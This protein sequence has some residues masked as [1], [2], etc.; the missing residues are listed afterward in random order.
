MKQRD[1]KQIE[2]FYRKVEHLNHVFLRCDTNVAKRD[3]LAAY[4][5]R[6]ENWKLEQIGSMLGISANH[7][8]TILLKMQKRIEWRKKH[9][10]PIYQSMTF[11]QTVG[12]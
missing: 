9:P 6:Q 11:N 10:V 3:W 7:A 1:E 2:L 8:R 12:D 5:A 4:A